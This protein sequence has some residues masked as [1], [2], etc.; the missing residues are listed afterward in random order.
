MKKI[1]F[2]V[3]GIPKMSGPLNISENISF[4]EKCFGQKLFKKI[5]LLISSV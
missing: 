2:L 4:T 3:Q 1:A 5:Y